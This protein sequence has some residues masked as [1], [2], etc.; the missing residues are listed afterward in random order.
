M[1]ALLDAYAWPYMGEELGN[2][3][4]TGARNTSNA[5]GFTNFW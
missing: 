5:K 1:H 4:A 3:N 2:H